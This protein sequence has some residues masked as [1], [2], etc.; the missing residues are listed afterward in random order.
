MN[1]FALL[2]VGFGGA[3]AI[4]W[5]VQ[6]IPLV[7]TVLGKAYSPRLLICKLLGP[8]DATVTLILIGGAWIGIGTAVTGIGMMVYNVITGIG[9]SMGVIF[10]KKVMVVRWEK[11]FKEEISNLQ[12]VSIIGRKINIS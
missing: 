8:F 6:Y 5:L 11:Q 12:E 10:L 7:S 3:F 4:V 1:A 2:L 9:L